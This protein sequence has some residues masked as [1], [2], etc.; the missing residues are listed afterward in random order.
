MLRI[1]SES[2]AHRYRII[3]QFDFHFL[4]DSQQLPFFFAPC[5][6]RRHFN[7]PIVYFFFLLAF[8]YFFS[9]FFSVGGNSFTASFH[10]IELLQFHHSLVMLC[11]SNCLLWF[12]K[13]HCFASI[14]RMARHPVTQMIN[15]TRERKKN[16]SKENKC[17]SRQRALIELLYFV[18]RYFTWRRLFYSHVEPICIR[19]AFS[20]DLWF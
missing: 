4:Q 6:L 3:R 13:F 14:T 7:D 2:C 8:D 17:T 20:S 5:Y 11:A 10:V 16:N 15:L 1:W 19:N 12:S 18:V 9:L